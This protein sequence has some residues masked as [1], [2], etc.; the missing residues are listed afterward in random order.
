MISFISK[1][2][3]NIKRFINSC[4]QKNCNH[5]ED[6]FTNHG[7]TLRMGRGRG[8]GLVSD[9]NLNNWGGW[10]ADLLDCFIAVNS[11]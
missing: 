1:L 7:A 2:Y 11:L 6:H 5:F 8:R 10:G 4:V 9:L 3:S